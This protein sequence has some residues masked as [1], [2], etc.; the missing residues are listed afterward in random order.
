MP[1][2]TNSDL[3]D[4]VQMHLPVEAQT[5]YRTAFNRAW[6]TYADDSEQERIAHRIAWAAVKRCYEKVGEDWS[7]RA[8]PLSA[9]V[10]H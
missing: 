2:R 8:G 9:P 7:P 5:I 10:R 4:Q 6:R 1:Y 3:P